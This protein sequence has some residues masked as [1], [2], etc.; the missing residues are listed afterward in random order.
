MSGASCASTRSRSKPCRSD[1]PAEHVL[2]RHGFDLDRVEAQLAP[3]TGHQHHDHIDTS[4]ITSVSLTCDTP[5][6]ATSLE[7]W[8]QELLA[9]QGSNILRTKGI[10]SIE[11]EDRKLVVQAVNMMLEGDYVGGWGSEARISRLVFIGRKLNYDHLKLGFQR[12]QPAAP[13]VA[14]KLTAT[15]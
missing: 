3:D 8:L 9:R 2:N 12:C 6:D 5:R 11:G 15:S 1:V 14:T 7:D 13:P 4:G 10:I